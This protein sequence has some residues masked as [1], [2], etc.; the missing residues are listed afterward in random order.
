MYKRIDLQS[1]FKIKPRHD[2]ISKMKCMHCG[3]EFS[4]YSYKVWTKYCSMPCSREAKR[5]DSL[6][7]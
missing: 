6:K 5:L 3:K 7:Q 2:V 1:I 4:Y